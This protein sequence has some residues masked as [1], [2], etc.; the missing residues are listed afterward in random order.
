[1][2]QR[3]CSCF[4]LDGSGFDPRGSQFFFPK[5]LS[6]EWKGKVGWIHS[7]LKSGNSLLKNKFIT[8]ESLAKENGE[9]KGL[10]QFCCSLKNETKKRSLGRK[11]NEKL[12]ELFG[13]VDANSFWMFPM[14][15]FK[16]RG[17]KKFEHFF[18]QEAKRTNERRK[19]K[20]RLFFFYQSF[21]IIYRILLQSGGFAFHPAGIEFFILTDSS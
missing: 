2:A 20:R 9:N 13:F 10:F 16:R 11:K 8:I 4:T 15:T 21:D 12:L 1:M 5:I 3:L 19:Q 17:E 14:K 18:S 6:I 7:V